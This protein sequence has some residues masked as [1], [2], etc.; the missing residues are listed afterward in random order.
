MVANAEK[1]FNSCYSR[2]RPGKVISK[3]IFQRIIDIT[4]KRN[5]VVPVDTKA[6]KENIIGSVGICHIAELTLTI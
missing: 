4:V 5:S 3:K 1:Y 6:V 2:V